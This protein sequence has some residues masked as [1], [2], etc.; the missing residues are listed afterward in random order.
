MSTAIGFSVKNYF[1]CKEGD[2]VGQGES[3][4]QVTAKSVPS[5]VPSHWNKI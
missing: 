5:Q 3:H 4:C 1:E 2:T